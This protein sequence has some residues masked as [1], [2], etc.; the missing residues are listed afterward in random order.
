MP[1]TPKHVVV[2]IGDNFATKKTLSKYVDCRFI[3]CASRSIFL[4]VKELYSEQKA[5]IESVNAIL[6]NLW[7]FL[8]R[9]ALREATALP[10]VIQK[11]MR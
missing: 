2:L 6:E 4:P 10:M 7:S 3:K 1:K 9:G 5:T 8:K 11:A